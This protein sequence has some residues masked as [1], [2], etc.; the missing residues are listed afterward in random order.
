MTLWMWFLKRAKG[1]RGLCEEQ[2][3][4]LEPQ[5]KMC[6]Y[7]HELANTTQRLPS[8]HERNAFLVGTFPLANP[9]TN[10]RG[11]QCPGT[12]AAFP[13]FRHWLSPVTGSHL[14]LKAWKQHTG[15]RSTDFKWVWVSP[16]PWHWS[17][18]VLPIY[19]FLTVKV[20]RTMA[21][22]WRHFMNDLS[23]NF[24]REQACWISAIN[25]DQEKD[26]KL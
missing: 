19:G 13:S 25:G 14:A 9:C 4:V 22:Q 3:G 15:K 16:P 21:A 11:K 5:R 20:G 23:L 6:S 1:E 7:L 10:V 26:S 17:L 8:D 18:D 12:H 24:F 2:A